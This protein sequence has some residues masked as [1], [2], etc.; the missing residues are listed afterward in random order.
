MK[1]KT[2]KII[3]PLIFIATGLFGAFTMY[4]A[5]FDEKVMFKGKNSPGLVNEL[6][7][8]RTWDENSDIMKSFFW[9]Y[10]YQG[11]FQEK[12]Y[13]GYEL[14]GYPMIGGILMAL[15]LF[16]AIHYEDIH[17]HARPKGNRKI[18]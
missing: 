16:G 3:L 18:Q 4:G 5:Q 7:P 2:I 14:I 9:N 8:I 11:W 13:Y 1:R 6:Y 12:G 15:F 10:E 17:R